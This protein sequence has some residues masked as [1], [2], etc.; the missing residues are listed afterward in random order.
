MFASMWHVGW[1]VGQ[2]SPTRDH[3]CLPH[4]SRLFGPHSYPRMWH[5]ERNGRSSNADRC[6][7][8]PVKQ[9]ISRCSVLVRPMTTGILADQVRR[10]CRKTHHTDAECQGWSMRR[11][12]LSIV[13]AKGEH[14][15]QVPST[16]VPAAGRVRRLTYPAASY[17]LFPSLVLP[18]G[19]RASGLGT[20][21]RTRV[22]RADVAPH[23][24]RVI[25]PHH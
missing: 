16:G 3:Q 10:S 21:A 2:R 18:H 19:G 25:T 1:H 4:R 6:S 12:S 20:P 11:M 23:S 17:S 9:K 13:V 14:L 24:Q 7:C 5:V 15:V 22:D 8:N